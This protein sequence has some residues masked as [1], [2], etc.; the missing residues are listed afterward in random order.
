MVKTKKIEKELE[1]LGIHTP[2]YEAEMK[3]YANGAQ[4]R[5]RLAEAKEAAKE[6]ESRR[7]YKPPKWSEMTSKQKAEAQLERISPTERSA[8]AR[9]YQEH[10]ATFKPTTKKEEAWKVQVKCADGVA[11]TGYVFNARSQ[12]DAE[13]RIKRDGAFRGCAIV[14]SEQIP[15][16]KKE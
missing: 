6:A 13:G 7:L 12:K 10:V 1:A 16:R 4:E 8:Q 11:R 2:G 15:I 5:K 3:E 9:M 14:H